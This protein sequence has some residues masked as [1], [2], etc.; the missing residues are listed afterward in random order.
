MKKTQKIDKN[1]L[2]NKEVKNFQKKVDE[3]FDGLNELSIFSTPSDLIDDFEE[4]IRSV[5]LDVAT[6]KIR[7]RPDWFKAEEILMQCIDVRNQAFKN[8]MKHPSAENHQA[9]KNARH[10]L[11]RKKR[12]ARQW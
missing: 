1:T 11:L 4:H 2:R 12:K 9:L 7:H 3:F 10:R 8:H 6:A 5:A